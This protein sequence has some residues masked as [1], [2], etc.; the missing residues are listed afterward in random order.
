MNK[1]VFIFT[2]QTLFA[3]QSMAQPSI[4][5]GHSHNDYMQ[6]RPLYEAI[7]LGYG[8][9][10]IDV[11]L[12]KH[13]QIRVA[14]STVFLSS[15]KTI[16]EMYFDPIVKM[17]KEKDTL[18]KY[19]GSAPLTL[20]IDIKTQADSTYIHLKKIFIKYASFITQYKNDQIIYWAPLKICI[21]GNKPWSAM[22]K[23]S[24]LFAKMDGP[25]FLGGPDSSLSDFMDINKNQVRLME[26][27]ST[28]YKKYLEY[29]KHFKTE[30]DLLLD[31][32]VINSLYGEIGIATRFWGVPN[33]EKKWK[34]LLLSGVR[35]INVDKLKKFA[36]FYKKFNDSLPTR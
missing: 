30:E 32:Q 5:H 31:M 6:K 9:L 7:E 28:H 29:K 20:M 14:H 16:E 26:R 22:L 11:C 25:F 36:L 34:V 10:E 8:S 2:I 27:A 17:I 33:T 1:I 12:D 21:S 19:S 3:I 15:K 13:N 35:W 18:F 4:P 23:D 24:L